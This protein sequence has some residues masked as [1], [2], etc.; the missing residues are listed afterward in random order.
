MAG[1]GGENTLDG[2]AKVMHPTMPQTLAVPM[3]GAAAV[4]A[5]GGGPPRGPK[6]DAGDFGIRIARDGTWYH[7]GGPI[8]RKELV[9]LFASVLKREADGTY[10]LETPV[11]RGRI[12]VEDA[13]F[14]AVEMV[15][16]DCDCGGGMPQ[17]CLGFRT[18]LD[19]IVTA[20]AEHPITVHLDPATREPRPYILVRPGLEA[21]INR[22]VFYELVAL[23]QPET[24]DGRVLMG[25]WSEGV[26]FP[27]DELCAVEAAEAGAAAE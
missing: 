21:K 11:E 4:A 17:Q 9:C 24:V 7:Q 13:P 14:V 27:I 10:V 6:R 19:E 1:G 15:W 18:N 16:R 26:F 8:R 20:N 25:V 23:A 2:E 3:P 12:E 5:R 22:A